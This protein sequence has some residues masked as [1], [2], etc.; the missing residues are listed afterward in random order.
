MIFQ[1]QISELRLQLE[2]AKSDKAKR[3]ELPKTPLL[4]MKETVAQVQR[5]MLQPQL[6]MQTQQNDKQKNKMKEEEKKK[7]KTVIATSP[8]QVQCSQLK[9]QVLRQL[10]DKERNEGGGRQAE[11]TEHAK[12]KDEEEHKV[13]HSQVG[14]GIL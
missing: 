4:E 13:E 11:Q 10:M 14:Q 8:A 6:Q 1:A 9:Q 5:E 7:K 12:H 3:F 2:Q